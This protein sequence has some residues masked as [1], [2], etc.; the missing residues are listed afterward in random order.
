MHEASC[1]E[2][3]SFVTLTYEEDPISLRYDHLQQ[4]FRRMRKRGLPVRYYA[5]GEYGDGMG[6]PHFHACLFGQDFRDDAVPWSDG[7]W[8]SAD[9]MELWGHGFCVAG[10]LSFESAAYVAGYVMKKMTGEAAFDHYWR[11]HE[12][13]GEAVQIE[14]EKGLMSRRPGIGSGWL[15]TYMEEVVRDDSV[16]VRGH[17][18]KP[19]RYYDKRIEAVDEVVFEAIKQ[20]RREVARKFAHLNTEDKLAVREAVARSKASLKGKR[21]YE[22]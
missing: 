19:P 15:D 9:L 18:S 10:E 21:S 22:T 4:F 1:H 5:C 6:R 3:N 2:R 14:P 20:R 11:V 13:T 8:L 17:E 16:I 7:L 12:D